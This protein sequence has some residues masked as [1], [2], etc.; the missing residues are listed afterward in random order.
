MTT[1]VTAIIVRE[2]RLLICQRRRDKAFPLKW[3]FPGGK[4]EAGE[5]LAG[6]LRREILEELGVQ[7]EI[8]CEVERVRHRYAELSA[9][10]EIVFYFARIVG[11]RAAFNAGGAFE[12]VVWVTPEDLPGYE[13]LDANGSLIVQIASGALPL[14]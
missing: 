2:S 1:V 6:A 4:V 14:E 8:G 12:K 10:I 9:S 3:E 13:F 5:S 11:E 7:I